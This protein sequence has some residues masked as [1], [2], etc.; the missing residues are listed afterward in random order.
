M[1]KSSS[2]RISSP[3]SGT[4]SRVPSVTV[5][6][7]R[8]Y[9]TVTV[10]QTLLTNI[11]NAQHTA[12][13]CRRVCRLIKNN[14]LPFSSNVFTATGFC[15]LLSLPMALL[16]MFLHVQIPGPTSLR[17]L[18]GGQY[19]FFI[20]HTHHNSV[21]SFTCSLISAASLKPTSSHRYNR[22]LDTHFYSASLAS[23]YLPI[24]FQKYSL[25]L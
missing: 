17:V 18:I 6:R 19:G 2:L 14:Y 21:I 25:R 10:S 11:R 7:I 23:F 12:T 24:R 3:A 16:L 8:G 20:P 9:T 13:R 5:T 22:L 4:P 1:Q 15:L